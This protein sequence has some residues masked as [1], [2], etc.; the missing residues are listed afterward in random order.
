M[1]QPHIT[2]NP[3][4]ALKNEREQL[5]LV[6]AVP[7]PYVNLFSDCTVIDM[8]RRFKRHSLPLIYLTLTPSVANQNTIIQKKEKNQMKR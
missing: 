3:V 6:T 8:N 4:R 1:R 2:H 5:L 7:Y